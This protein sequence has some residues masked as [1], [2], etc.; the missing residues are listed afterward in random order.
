MPFV[1]TMLYLLTLIAF[2]G[3][4]MNLLLLIVL[5]QI[6]IQRKSYF[7][8]VKSL[9]V[10]DLGLPLTFCI[11]RLSPYYVYFVSEFG[12]DYFLYAILLNLLLLAAEHYV[13]ILKPLYY[14]SWSR[15]R[16]IALRLFLIWTV[17]LLLVCIGYIIPAPKFMINSIGFSR[18][19]IKEEKDEI[20]IEMKDAFRIPFV[21][22][23]LIVMTIV[24]VYIYIE[25]R[26]QQRLD[27]EQNQNAR[28]NN[29]AFVTT[30]LNLLSF[31]LCWLPPVVVE[32]IF[33][34]YKPSESDDFWQFYD[35]AKSTIPSIVYLNSIFDPMIYALRLTDVWKKWSQMF[36]CCCR[37]CNCCHDR[38]SLQQQLHREMVQIVVT[39]ED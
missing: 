10:A 6:P 8:L 23:V 17:P 20:S 2:A 24:Y 28:R 21:I 4:L 35:L 32:V 18:F 3:I 39:N 15:C 38:L 13:A 37:W 1:V 33:Q 30:V 11:V 12:Y 7:A 19:G 25:V 5:C 14:R 16:Y 27:V 34:I 31:F 29:R 26:K 22:L 9:T 36:C